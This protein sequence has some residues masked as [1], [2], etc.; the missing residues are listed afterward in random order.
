[1]NNAQETVSFWYQLIT[2]HKQT[3]ALFTL[4][5]A[6]VFV[7]SGIFALENPAA[8]EAFAYNVTIISGIM[9]FG[10]VGSLAATGIGVAAFFSTLVL[11]WGIG[12][13]AERIRLLQSAKALPYYTGGDVFL[14]QDLTLSVEENQRRIEAQQKAL[15]DGDTMALCLFRKKDI[16][17]FTRNHE[18][19]NALTLGR[20]ELVPEYETCDFSI[21]SPESFIAYVKVAHE[22]FMNYCANQRI[23]LSKGEDILRIT[24]QTM[25][26]PSRV[27]S[28]IIFVLAFCA[29]TFAQTKTQRVI[30]GLGTAAHTVP[31]AGKQVVYTFEKGN[32]TRIAD[33]ANSVSGLIASTG[34]MGAD[35][36]N[37][38]ALVGVDIAGVQIS[39][40]KKIEQK[41]QP[42]PLFQTRMDAAGAVLPDSANFQQQLTQ[43]DKESKKLAE[44]G[45]SNG[46]AIFMSTTFKYIMAL[47]LYLAFIS[48][49][50]SNASVNESRLDFY[51][52]V[53]YGATIY[54]IGAFFRTFG[55]IFLIICG[56][57][58][59]TYVAYCFFVA[60]SIMPIFGLIFSWG[61]VKLG[62]MMAI[63]KG[64]EML[65]DVMLKNPKT[66]GGGG[67]NHPGKWDGNRHPQ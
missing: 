53:K 37:F 51:K 8:G 11:G 64:V 61:A 59:L 29:S 25:V 36:D 44:L 13:L 17:L 7:M 65:L 48:Q 6:I 18:G 50:I 28:T 66:S 1:M 12:H 16:T 27:L 20:G 41:E 26:T 31:A 46:L 58:L 22:S 4:I 35:A 54:S 38:G 21:E 3:I 52:G 40:A 57:V 34:R 67:N 23:A 43:L 33:G 60:D 2:K 15:T 30:D 14:P 19:V 45:L 42:K 5:N 55:F 9:T 32:I 63:T 39:A 24:A 47:F 49:F 62:A 10:L 56:T